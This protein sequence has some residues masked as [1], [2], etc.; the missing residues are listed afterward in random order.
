MLLQEYSKDSYL[1]PIVSTPGHQLPGGKLVM[2]PHLKWLGS[3][4]SDG[5][6]SIRAV[7]N[8]VY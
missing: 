5:A 3:V 2:S 7:G 6:L 1:K 8:L 4:G